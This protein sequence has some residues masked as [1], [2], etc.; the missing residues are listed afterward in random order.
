M[1]LVRCQNVCIFNDTIK[2]FIYFFKISIHI[3]RKI[4]TAYCLQG[5]N[6]FLL[7]C[8]QFIVIHYNNMYNID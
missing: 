8:I 4:K 1:F 7:C 6:F 2:Q 5:A 3:V